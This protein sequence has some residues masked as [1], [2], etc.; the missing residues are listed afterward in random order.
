MA[1][2]DVKP[3]PPKANDAAAKPAAESDN[4][5]SSEAL[6]KDSYFT[7]DLNEVRNPG[8]APTDANV[9]G[10]GLGTDAKAT[11]A[12]KKLTPELDQLDTAEAAV[13]EATKGKGFTDTVNSADGPTKGSV[14]RSYD[15]NGPLK[16]FQHTF[17]KDGSVD[18][19]Q[20]APT[21]DIPYSKM[22][23]KDGKATVT[24][25]GASKELS[26][27]ET[28]ALTAK[29]NEQFGQA[30]GEF[31]IGDKTGTWKLDALGNTAVSD[32]PGVRP[33]SSM[34]LKP[35]NAKGDV[36]YKAEVKS[37][38]EQIG[39]TTEATGDKAT[40]Q[41]V[42]DYDDSLASKD[43]P[44]TSQNRAV[45]GFI[46][47]RDGKSLPITVA[48]DKPAGDG[49]VTTIRRDGVSDTTFSS[50]SAKNGFKTSETIY[51]EK[52]TSG[53]ASESKFDP[54]KNPNHVSFEQNMVDG[55]KKTQR[56]IAGGGT[57]V[58]ITNA[59]GTEMVGGFADD[60]A[61]KAGTPS[62]R[63]VTT[64]DGKTVTDY[65]AGT[66]FDGVDAV[67]KR[68]EWTP[69]S[70]N[71][72]G[73][74]VPGA[75]KAIG[76]DDKE[77][78]DPKI[79]EAFSK[80]S[81]S[82]EKL[83]DNR[84]RDV[85]PDGTTVTTDKLTNIT[86]T[87]TAD[88]V[89]HSWPKPGD[90]N[91]K[92]HSP[93]ALAKI[94][95]L[96]GLDPKD[97]KFNERIA[98]VTSVVD[99][100][101]SLTGLH[102]VEFDATKNPEG[103]S[104]DMVQRDTAGNVIAE[105]RDGKTPAVGKPGEANYKAPANY[106]ENIDHQNG[107]TRTR[108]YE[109]AGG[110]P[111]QR[112]GNQEV[113]NKAGEMI[114]RTDVVGNKV[115]TTDLVTKQQEVRD[116]DAATWSRTGADGKVIQQGRMTESGNTRIALDSNNDITRGERIDGPRKGDSYTFNRNEDGSVKSIEVSNGPRNGNPAEKVTL[117]RAADGSWTTNP[118]GAKIPGFDLATKGPDGKITGEFSVTA[119][120]ELTFETADKQMKQILR[121]DGGRDT[122]NLRDYSRVR[123]DASGNKITQY[124][125][126]YGPKNNP[127]DGWRT[128]TA[129]TDAN[130]R[131]EVVFDDK[132]E[133]RPT[134]MVRDSGGTNN[135][136]EVEF[137]NG[138]SFKVDNWKD[139]KMTRTQG[140][141]SETLYNTGTLGNDGR[142]QWAKGTESDGAIT[143][144]D[145]RV[146]TGELPKV[147]Q[148]D[149]ETGKVTSVYADGRQVEADIN[150]KL[151][152]VK[153]GF[154]GSNVS[155]RVYDKNGELKRIIQGGMTLDR[156]PPNLDGTTDWKVNSG[157]VD[158]KIPRAQVVEG[159]G[160]KI[161]IIGTKQEKGPDGKTT[162]VLDGAKLESNGRVVTR[163][164]AGRP[165]VIDARGQKWTMLAPSKPGTPA[166]AAKN[167]P[168]VPETPPTWETGKPDAK[169]Q[170]KG[171]MKFY[172]NGNVGVQN[173]A[174]RE[175]TDTVNNDGSVS[176]IDK[177]G[178]ERERVNADKTYQKRDEQGKLKEFSNTKGEVTTLDYETTGAAPGVTR[179]VTKDSTG[180]VLSVQ[181]RDMDA[182]PNPVLRN[183][184]F[185][186]KGEVTLDPTTK[187][188]VFKSNAE[189]EFDRLGTKSEK[190]PG[191][192]A[193]ESVSTSIDTKGNT[194]VV[195]SLNGRPVETTGT[196]GGDLGS[197]PLKFQYNAA[198]ANDTTP[199]QIT[200][201]DGK[202]YKRAVPKDAKPNPNEPF[203]PPNSNIYDINGVNHTLDV[204][205]SLTKTESNIGI[206]PAFARQLLPGQLQA[207]VAKPEAKPSTTPDAARDAAKEK[208]RLAVNKELAQS[209]G[210]SETQVE[211]A[212]GLAAA[213][214]I[215]PADA[216]K[217]GLDM[218]L[219]GAKEAKVLDKLTPE[220]VT[221]MARELD[222]LLK[223]PNEGTPPSAATAA[224]D[225]I[226]KM[227][228]DP[229]LFLTNIDAINGMLPATST[230]KPFA[231]RAFANG[232]LAKYKLPEDKRVQ[233]PA[234]GG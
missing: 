143:F 156:M 81:I 149:R 152:R 181:A 187:K 213:L 71:A 212:R 78:T 42:V 33:G 112:E 110:P 64:A 168:A 202:V 58:Q 67:V 121:A 16:N 61:L 180:K 229:N 75:L 94:G 84:T 117:E 82:T 221:Q 101:G 207:E 5:S 234:P 224:Q 23:F 130:G 123:E 79:L 146:N 172:E 198:D 233:P 132:K 90:P 14:T 65:P 103:R 91:Y 231:N 176:Q 37:T 164:A 36:K 18:L 194:R 209:Y 179:A 127:E 126:G 6:L 111:P 98:S 160:G 52:H 139:G 188:P 108:S 30:K 190:I 68:T 218:F 87:E 93:E 38:A 74:K 9:L 183:A 99:G 157:G 119:K 76:A 62:W 147:A 175:L 54:A 57:E 136:F 163:D 122:Y 32:I 120:G 24:E 170:F 35:P 137:A 155:E 161:D 115:T 148:F 50:P 104:F 142:I 145:P 41:R 226:R 140:G 192:N 92:P 40:G 208:E 124:W 27:A 28:K 128:G 109:K 22:T 158:Y 96:T 100:K 173:Q 153:P 8:V 210:I 47:G 77:I 2:T 186:E 219:N 169:K 25:N 70:V 225:A 138:T 167:T 165:T 114:K 196:T 206:D 150:G 73:E 184:A 29:L 59:N 162:D 48:S 182:K 227:F 204:N 39:Y 97:S 133:G 3:T 199:T 134:R 223:K 107:G 185:N 151:T 17:N 80:K 105:V 216:S 154:K 189:V 21:T 201:G 177:R 217:Q 222:Q 106:L 232:V 34:E 11:E 43:A 125:D 220:Y 86:T 89:T 203:G 131:T 1:E 69:P 193:G 211:L 95:Q 85:K 171:E 66:K 116:Y 63:R 178:V 141:K 144:D 83:D 4:T 159:A 215:A 174:N 19:T 45:E 20:T 88:R 31:K 60:A 205:G 191:A 49:S 228:Q 46:A 200:A 230:L 51:P 44:T 197:Q 56:S 26:E 7:R 72:K 129:K 13:R 15:A 55:S 113:F 118:A 102:R 12:Y 195:K 10:T 214:N 135:K 53:I 166:D